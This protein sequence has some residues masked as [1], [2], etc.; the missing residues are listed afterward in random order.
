MNRS[1]FAVASFAL[2]L[3]ALPASADPFLFTA[4]TQF[5]TVVSSFTINF[6]DTGDGKLDFG[7]VT[8]FS[9]VNFVFADILMTILAG[10]PDI[11]GVADCGGAGSPPCVALG[12]FHS[13]A[14]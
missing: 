13:T 4:T 8:A 11:P 10:I 3:S 7:E 14:G 1:I 9:G 5:P 2:S 6:D 12:G